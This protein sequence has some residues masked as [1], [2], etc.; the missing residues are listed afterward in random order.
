MLLRNKFRMK[1]GIGEPEVLET[2]PD[3]FPQLI[4]GLSPDFGT[5]NLGIFV[6]ILCKQDVFALHLL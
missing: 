1:E 4:F 3:D 5:Q 6:V 2:I